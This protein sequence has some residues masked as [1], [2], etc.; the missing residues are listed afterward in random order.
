MNINKAQKDIFN[1]LLKGER[2]GQ[3]EVDENRIFI[4]PNGFYGF[5]L[6]KVA[7]QINVEK[8]QPMTKF[9]DFNSVLSTENA[10]ELTDECKIVTRPIKKYAIKLKGN[11]KTVYVNEKYLQYYQ[12]PHFYYDNNL[13]VVTEKTAR[14]TETVVGVILPIRPKGE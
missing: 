10:V 11:E 12:N 4:T 6:P 13:V 2:A 3:F 7:L 8:I 1:C 9:I 5:V 14:D